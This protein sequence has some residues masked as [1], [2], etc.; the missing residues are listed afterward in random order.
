MI[1]PINFFVSLTVSVTSSVTVAV[2]QL[3]LSLCTTSRRRTDGGR[4]PLNLML[5][6]ASSSG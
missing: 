5:V 3:K 2:T 4:A 6:L 1:D